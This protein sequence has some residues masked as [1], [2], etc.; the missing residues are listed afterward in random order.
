VEWGVDFKTSSD[1]EVVA[2]LYARAPADT[3]EARS[4]YCMRRL[5][6]AFALVAATKDEIVG[7]RDPL[8]IRPLCLGKLPD[9]WVMASESC[10]LYNIGAE[11]VREIEPGETVVIDKDGP[12]SYLWSGRETGPHSMCVF[13]QIYIARPDSILAGQLAHSAR[14]RMG[15]ELARMHPADADICIGVPDSGTA[16]AAGYAEESG[17]PYS[18]GLIKNRYVNRTFIQPDQALRDVG[19]Q[20]KFSPLIDM[21]AGKRVVAVDD[22]IVR[23]T[24]TPRIVELLRK[25]GAT[26]VHVRISSPPIVSPCHFGI[27]MSTLDQLIAANNTVEEIRQKIDA[28]S[29]G[30]L[31]VDRLMKA[32]G[33]V[34]DSYCKGCFTGRYPIPVQLEMSKLELEEPAGV[35][36]D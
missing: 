33:I 15:K 14:V 4:A 7:V 12:R 36:A 16:H 13:E 27:D 8:G 20:L 1:S 34:D 17:I 11:F 22:S 35:K 18:E 19:V 28:D 5:R 30:F 3:W 29:L 32:V 21:I 23:G 25:A 31:D 10:A 6:G 9:G 24:T 2:E 26:E